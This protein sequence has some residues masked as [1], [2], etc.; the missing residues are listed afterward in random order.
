MAACGIMGAP[1]EM[2][3]DREFGWLLQSLQAPVTGVVFD[4]SP[5]VDDQSSAQRVPVRELLERHLNADNSPWNYPVYVVAQDEGFISIDGPGADGQTVTAVA[6]FTSEERIEAY[7]EA[8]GNAG[9][10]CA[11]QN[12]DEAR[13]FVKGIAPH[14]AAVA[15]NPTFADGQRSAKHCFAIATLLD[16]YLVADENSSEKDT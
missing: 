15:L 4:P 10:A 3:N 12:I 8:T 1:R 2:N 5:S 16:K 14:A 13:S 9:T 7:L 11:M 6:F